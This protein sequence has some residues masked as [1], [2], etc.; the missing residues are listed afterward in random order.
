MVL[1]FLLLFAGLLASVTY[2][3][4]KIRN[5]N[6]RSDAENT[7]YPSPTSFFLQLWSSVVETLSKAVTLGFSSDPQ[8]VEDKCNVAVQ[9]LEEGAEYIFSSFDWIASCLYAFSAYVTNCGI[10]FMQSA[11]QKL[12]SVAQICW[13]EAR[14]F[15]FQHQP[16]YN[17]AD[18]QGNFSWYLFGIVVSL[19]AGF[20]IWVSCRAIST[21]LFNQRQ[22]H[23]TLCDSGTVFSS[24]NTNSDKTVCYSG[25]NL[26]SWSFVLRTLLYILVLGFIVSIPWE[27]IR[28]YQS[29][30]A[31]KA[32]VTAQVNKL[33]IYYFLFIVYINK[34]TLLVMI[35]IIMIRATSNT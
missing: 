6:Y 12:S 2:C 23:Q 7:S 1:C 31:E 21:Y 3:R 35:I 4:S 25:A 14:L 18:I 34:F 19:I 24:S 11:I 8:S 15:V 9:I 13:T 27:F 16:S 28:I 5:H 26:A 20:V 29:R 10:G 32:A 30:V 22:Q 33:L 17:F